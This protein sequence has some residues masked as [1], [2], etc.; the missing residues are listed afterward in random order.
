MKQTTKQMMACLLTEI[1]TTREE[2]TITQAEMKADRQERK[3]E[4]KTNQEMLARMEARIEA[5]NEKF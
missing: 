4:I 5:K 2:K 1:R 3:A